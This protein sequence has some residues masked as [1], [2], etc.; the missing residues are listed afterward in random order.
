V[1]SEAFR[2]WLRDRYSATVQ[3]ARSSNA[4]RIE[5][6]Y[7][8]LDIAF[9][10]DGLDG[11][12][13]TFRYSK[14]DAARAL[15]NPTKIAIQ[16]D[17]YNGLASLRDALRLY[18]DFRLSDGSLDPPQRTED[19][20]LGPTRNEGRQFELERHLQQALRLDLGQ[21]ERGLIVADG[22]L[23]RGV[24]SGFV[25]IFA[26][27]ELGTPVVI[28]LKAGTARR[29]AIGQ[30][31]GYMGDIQSEDASSKVRGIL[32]AGGFDRSCTGAAR[33]IPN[34]KLLEYRFDFSFAS[35]KQE[36]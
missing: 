23:E 2:Q 26:K 21:L 34:L 33:I 16:G 14:Q 36:S 18:R 6:A 11:L 31:L 13:A 35:P 28:E 12:A 27:D 22:G 24:A 25:D 3:A 10:E 5:E 15:P 1:R 20:Q 30:I 4:R 32:V 17:I 9:E 8:D 29:D 19:G 7:G